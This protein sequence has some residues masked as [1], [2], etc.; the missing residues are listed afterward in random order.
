MDS[1]RASDI[2]E[3]IFS[4]VKQS[5]WIPQYN[6]DFDS[7]WHLVHRGMKIENV[8]AFLSHFNL[9]VEEKLSGPGRREVSYNLLEKIRRACANDESENKTNAAV[10]DATSDSYTD[11][12]D[13]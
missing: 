6:F 8:T 10:E 12:F 11:E 9:A 1:K 4:T 2:I 13:L 7:L 3:N 5:T